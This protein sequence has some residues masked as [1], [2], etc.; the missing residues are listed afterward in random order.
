MS[1]PEIN[2][3]YVGGKV[4]MGV[5]I[6]ILEK[7]LCKVRDGRYYLEF[8]TVRKLRAAVSDI[9]SAMSTAHASR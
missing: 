2:A 8:N 3:W 1:F 6:Q 9:Y 7:S 5:A 4:V